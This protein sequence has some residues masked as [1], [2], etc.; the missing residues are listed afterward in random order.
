MPSLPAAASPVGGGGLAGSGT[1]SGHDALG[2]RRLL[3]LA[4]GAV[5]GQMVPRRRRLLHLAAGAALASAGLSACAGG[6]YNANGASVTTVASPTNG[7]VDVSNVKGYGPILVTSRGYTLYML[8]SDAPNS[9][10]CVGSCA[11]VWPPLDSSGKLTAGAGVNPKFLSSFQR[12]GGAHQ[13]AYHGHALY[14]Y[15]RD[16]GP[17]MT[18][19]EGVE[20]YGGIWW[21]VSPAGQPV[22]N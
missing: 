18:T 3:H 16:T 1:G 22:K 5:P 2:R 21:V 19:G 17:G 11:I 14:T 12:S 13:V 8:S 20:T 7:T 15:E 10:T 6:S 9:S 4:S